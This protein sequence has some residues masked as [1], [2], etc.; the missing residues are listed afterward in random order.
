MTYKRI[1]YIVVLILVVTYVLRATVGN[2]PIAGSLIGF[3]IGLALLVLTAIGVEAVLKGFRPSW[4]LAKKQFSARDHRSS[5]PVEHLDAFLDD[6]DDPG[7]F[8]DEDEDEEDDGH[9]HDPDDES[10]VWDD[11]D[12]GIEVVF[13][14]D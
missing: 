4:D 7:E 9:Y 1:A 10:D 2:I 5:T 11:E 6:E 12:L 3:C 8:D 14:N 13:G